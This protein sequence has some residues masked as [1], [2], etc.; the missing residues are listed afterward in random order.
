[1]VHL[2][3]RRADRMSNFEKI[4][5]SEI[6]LGDFLGSLN[7]IDSPWE[8]DFHREFCDRRSSENCNA[9]NCP[10]MEERDDP[11]WW[12]MKEATP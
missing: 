8:E 10:H 3:E 2:H 4:T 11:R 5:S 6:T 12:L 7:L 9:E 1:M